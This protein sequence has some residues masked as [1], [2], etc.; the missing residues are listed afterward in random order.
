[1]VHKYTLFNCLYVLDIGKMNPEKQVELYQS[2]IHTGPR[3]GYRHV[4]SLLGFLGFLNVYAMRV[5]LSVA[6][7]AMVNST[8]NS[9]IANHTNITDGTCPAPITPGNSTSDTTGDF[10]WDEKTQSLVLGCF[11]YGYVLTQIPGGRAAELFGGK[12][13]FGIGIL[14]TSIFTILMP[15]AAK[16]DF[17]LLVAVRVI[18]GMGEGVTFPV[19]HAMLAHWSPPLERSKLSTFI[20]AGSMMGTVA[21]LPLTGLIC[22]YWGWEAAFYVFGAFGLVWFIFWTIF[23]YDTPAK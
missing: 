23:V 21:S 3:F 13:I 7:V 10:D 4:F 11:F 5:N 16:T 8:S 1:M 18:E 15:I 22:D 2:L 12:W 14:I 19:M 20:Y 6:I 17:R 9:G